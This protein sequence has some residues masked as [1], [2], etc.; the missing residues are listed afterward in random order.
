MPAPQNRCEREPLISRSAPAAPKW[1]RRQDLDAVDLTGRDFLAAPAPSQPLDKRLI[2]DQL[3]R[4]PRA[5][6]R[7]PH[8]RACSKPLGD[9]IRGGPRLLGLDEFDC[10]EPVEWPVDE[11]DLERQVGFDVG[12]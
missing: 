8:R 1:P 4:R 2:S 5:G 12:L 9:R 11:E 7:R 3:K 10:A 6:V